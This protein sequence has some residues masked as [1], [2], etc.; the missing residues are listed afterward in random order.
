MNSL[1]LLNFAIEDVYLAVDWKALALRKTQVQPEPLTLN[2]RIPQQH[3]N[4]DSLLSKCLRR[5]STG[6]PS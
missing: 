3:A 5:I 6:E 4:A 1:I 2:P